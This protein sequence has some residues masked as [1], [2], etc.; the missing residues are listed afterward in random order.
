MSAEMVFSAMLVWLDKEFTLCLQN[1][2]VL[3]VVVGL[4]AI[5]IK[6]GVKADSLCSFIVRPVQLVAHHGNTLGWLH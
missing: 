3:L 2:G 5:E 4:A 6:P 1:N